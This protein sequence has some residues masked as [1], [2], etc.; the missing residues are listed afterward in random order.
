MHDISLNIIFCDQSV[1]RYFLELFVLE[2][3]TILIYIFMLPNLETLVLLLS[4]GQA[5]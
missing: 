4:S 1:S 5:S 2:K 3:L